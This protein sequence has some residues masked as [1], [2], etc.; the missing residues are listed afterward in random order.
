MENQEK[1][2]LK[3]SLINHRNT[4]VNRLTSSTI[5]LDWCDEIKKNDQQKRITVQGSNGMPQVVQIEQYMEQLKD[6]IRGALEHI[7]KID[8]L[9]S[10]EES[11]KLE[12]R[13]K[14]NIKTFQKPKKI[15]FP[16]DKVKIA[17]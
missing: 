1:L 17:G 2:T 15:I 3:Q 12:D 5:D 11:G 9:L 4:W 8:N 10:Q 6:N 16:D 14:T 13:Y 7:E